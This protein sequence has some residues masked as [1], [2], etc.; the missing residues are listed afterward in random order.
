MLS[1]LGGA[2]ESAVSVLIL[3]TAE[4]DSAVATNQHYVTREL[5]VGAQVTFVESLGLRRPTLRPDDLARMVGRVRRAFGASAGPSTRQPARARPANTTIVSPLVVPVHR[6][7][8]RPLNRAVLRRATA[9]W[10]T[11]DR[12]RVLWT[13]TPVTYGLEA[14]ADVVVYHCVDLLARFP[15]VDPG[16]VA[17]GERD[18][19]VRPDVVAIATSDAVRVHLAS[20]GFSRIEL[21]ENVADT[22]VF[23][24]GSR[25]AA[26]RRPAVIRF[27]LW[28][29][30][31]SGLRW[32]TAKPVGSVRWHDYR[33]DRVE[34]VQYVA[35][36]VGRPWGAGVD[37][38]GGQG[39]VPEGHPGHADP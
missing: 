27:L 1:T 38:A 28:I 4:W 14:A 35:A 19:A 24:R 8:T 34:R 22:T 15:G 3:G 9:T 17:N 23:Q 21:L 36:V 18:L 16:A 2:T 6:A 10:L 31:P 7:P 25:P 11:S 20:S 29:L 37:R 39:V 33:V 12:P 13:F 26:E 5:A 32:G 30:R